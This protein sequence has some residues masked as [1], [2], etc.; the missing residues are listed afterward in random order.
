MLSYPSLTVSYNCL[1]NYSNSEMNRSKSI[2]PIWVR[3]DASD[4]IRVRATCP[5]SKFS[6]NCQRWCFAVFDYVY[7][8]VFTNALFQDTTCITQWV[9]VRSVS[10]DFDVVEKSASGAWAISQIDLPRQNIQPTAHIRSQQISE[11]INQIINEW[12]KSIIDARM[13]YISN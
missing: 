12:V 13:Y 3:L 6:T 8:N 7:R 4:K 1:Y 10:R 2:M 11:R 5:R 9:V